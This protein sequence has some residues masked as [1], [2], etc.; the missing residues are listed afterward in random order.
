MI[1]N[2]SQSTENIFECFY[3][4]TRSQQRGQCDA[5]G[6]AMRNISVPRGE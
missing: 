2:H 4:G 5:C 3:C 6:S 1:P